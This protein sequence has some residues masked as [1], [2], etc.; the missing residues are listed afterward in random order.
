MHAPKNLPSQSYLLRCW[1]E[2]DPRLGERPVWRFSL[3]EIGEE[4]RRWGFGDLEALVAFLRRVTGVG[5]EEES[6]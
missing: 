6:V 1:Q 4:G 2:G 5:E 3:Q